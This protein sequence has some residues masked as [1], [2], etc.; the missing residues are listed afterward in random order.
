MKIQK[1]PEIRKIPTILNTPDHSAHGMTL[2]A[3]LISSSSI[4]CGV[5]FTSSLLGHN[6]EGP[7]KGGYDTAAPP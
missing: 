6:E 3:L 2:P 4:L 5:A 1:I 7:P